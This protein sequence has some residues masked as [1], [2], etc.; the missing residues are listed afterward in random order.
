MTIILATGNKH[1]IREFEAMLGDTD[2]QVYAYEEILESLEIVES[3]ASFS[4]N[5]SLKVKAIYQALYA[6]YI[7]DSQNT[8]S[9][10]TQNTQTQGQGVNTDFAN[11]QNLAYS[12]MYPLKAPLAIIAE[13]SGLCV[14][15]LNG[16]PGIYSARYASFKH[17]NTHLDSAQSQELPTM[18]LNTSHIAHNSTD[19]ENLQCLIEHIAPFAPTPAFF[20]AHIALIFVESLPLP[21]IEQCYIECFEG[22]LEGIAISEARGTEG[23]GYDPIFV[24][25]DLNPHKQT[26]AEFTPSAK[27]AISHR[28][29]AISACLKYLHL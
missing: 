10:L 15:A 19:S 21:P 11:S 9:R 26:L 28:K 13:D 22:R 3:G 27:N 20:T 16:E 25:L 23:F 2:A 1:K 18:S 5:A 4:E 12:A 6:K 8:E 17:F 7:Q 24:P 14:P 29:R